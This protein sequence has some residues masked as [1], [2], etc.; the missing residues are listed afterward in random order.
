M[1]TTLPDSHTLSVSTEID[2]RNI[3]LRV[4]ASN[5]KSADSARNEVALMLSTF[6]FDKLYRLTAGN[7]ILQDFCR[8]QQDAQVTWSKKFLSGK[9][10]SIAINTLDGNNI[11]VYDLLMGASLFSRSLDLETNRILKSHLINEACQWRNYHALAYRAQMM[12]KLLAK[13]ATATDDTSIT[14]TSTLLNSILVD[15]NTLAQTYWGVGYAKSGCILN[16]LAVLYKKLA[17]SIL[18][19]RPEDSGKLLAQSSQFSEQAIKQF[20]IA[21]ILETHQHS[22]E[23]T[24]DVT[25]N[26]GILSLLENAEAFPDWSTAKIKFQEWVTPEV[27]AMLETQAKNATDKLLRDFKNRQSSA[28]THTDNPASKNSHAFFNQTLNILTDK[29]NSELS[30]ITPKV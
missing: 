6:D 23:I 28:I 27:F 10:P 24:S 13:N 30:T 22:Q 3:M 11:M 20:L 4:I 21:N 19:D 2:L 1:P 9:Y 17:D 14:H 5:E 8:Q 29:I 15:T 18:T 7:Q 12:M 26:E 25:N 16:Q